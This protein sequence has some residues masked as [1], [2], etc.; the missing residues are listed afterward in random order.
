MM[1]VVMIIVMVIIMMIIMMIAWVI[2]MMMCMVFIM[3]MAMMIIMMITMTVIMMATKYR[4][5]G[6]KAFIDRSGHSNLGHQLKRAIDAILNL[7]P[8]EIRGKLFTPNVH[9]D[10]IYIRS[11]FATIRPER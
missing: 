3:M 5:L 6:S 8:K 7:M 9:M 1:I 11:L 2:M 4:Y 10:A